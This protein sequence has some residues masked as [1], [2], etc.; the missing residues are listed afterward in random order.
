MQAD[1]DN[2]GFADE[3]DNCPKHANVDQSDNDGD[4]IGN[5]CDNSPNDFNINQT[6]SDRDGVGDG[7]DNCP[8]LANPNQRDT[9]RD[10]VGDI[11]DNCLTRANPNQQDSDGDGVG[12][13]CDTCPF[14]PNVAANNAD[15]DGDGVHDNCDNCPAMA[16]PDQTDW[17]HNGVGHVCETPVLYQSMVLAL[18]HNV[19]QQGEVPGVYDAMF[20]ASIDMP[21]RHLLGGDQEAEIHRGYEWWMISRDRLH[22]NWPIVDRS[23]EGLPP[24]TVLGLVYCPDQ[25][26]Q[27]EDPDGDAQERARFGDDPMIRVNGW[28]PCEQ[29]EGIIHSIGSKAVR[30]CGGDIGADPGHG[31]CWFEVVDDQFD[32]A[33]SRERLPRYS[34]VGLVHTQQEAG[35]YDGTFVWN[36]QTYSALPNEH[37]PQQP[38]HMP[39][40]F[41]W[42]HGGDQGG[43]PGEGYYWFEKLSGPE[44][45]VRPDLTVELNES[46]LATQA[47]NNDDRDHDGL[48]DRLENELAETFKPYVWFDSEETARW[49]YDS[50]DG[51]VSSEPITLF[52]VRPVNLTTSQQCGNSLRVKIK[53]V[54]LFRWDG[55]YVMPVADAGIF[56]GLVEAGVNIGGNVCD[57]LLLCDYDNYDDSHPGDNDDAEFIVESND[58]GTTWTLVKVDL[59]F[60]NETVWPTASRLEV[61]DLTHPKIYV[62]AGKHHM[63][64]NRDYD[65]DWDFSTESP[66]SDHGRYDLVDGDGFRVLVDLQ[67]LELGKYNNVGE[68]EHPGEAP[69]FVDDLS[70]YY[71]PWFNPH[72]WCY[73]P[74]TQFQIRCGDRGQQHSAWGWDHFY[75]VKPIR[76]KWIGDGICH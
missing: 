54:F 60:A 41:R 38:R 5:A 51:G 42:M 39:P 15:A 29:P 35:G 2:D 10:G 25:V 17:D 20:S 74:Q 37:H 43:E 1:S 7:S 8:S 75:D 49:Y 72:G 3:C 26:Y 16:N 13:L 68:P 48:K 58:G 28:N 21:A 61:H 27:Y 6:D 32:D 59:S 47:G 50:P 73:D 36:G 33:T 9:D 53:W 76:H 18:R 24:G 57:G 11:C 55:G 62:S 14:T 64:L 31:Y 22:D 46:L 30:R 67:S 63:F 23:F 19:N 12:N 40:G 45:V 4:Y 52:Q 69:F 56:D 66:Y 70:F 34:V 65:D 44:I 71:E